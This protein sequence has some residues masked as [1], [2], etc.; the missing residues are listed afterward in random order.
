MGTVNGVDSVGQYHPKQVYCYCLTK[1]C[2]IAI[3][4]EKFTI[5]SD[6]A[7]NDEFTV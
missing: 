1:Y 6:F 5:N 2:D 3:Y 4:C 7:D